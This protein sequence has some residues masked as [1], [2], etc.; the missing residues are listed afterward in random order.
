MP[1]FSVTLV[2]VRPPLSTTDFS[3]RPLSRSAKVDTVCDAALTTN[4]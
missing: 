2:G 3:S 4:R 1:S